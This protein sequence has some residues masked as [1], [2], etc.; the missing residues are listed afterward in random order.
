VNVAVGAPV[1][2]L[3][4]VRVIVG[5]FVTVRVGVKVGVLE[6]LRVNERFPKLFVSEFSTTTLA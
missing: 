6:M 2:V 4:G 3:V 5:V 1:G